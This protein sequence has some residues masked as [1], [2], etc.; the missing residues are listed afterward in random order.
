MHITPHGG[1]GEGIGTRYSGYKLIPE[2]IMVP[3]VTFER[4]ELILTG[5]LLS[6]TFTSTSSTDVCTSQLELNRLQTMVIAYAM[7]QSGLETTAIAL[8][9]ITGD[10]G[11][12]IRDWMS[13]SHIILRQ[14]E[15]RWHIEISKNGR[16]RVERRVK[17]TGLRS[18]RYH[19]RVCTHKILMQLVEH[20]GDSQCIHNNAQFTLVYPVTIGDPVFICKETGYTVR[21]I[22]GEFRALPP[23]SI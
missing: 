21:K 12:S 18:W 5:P 20:T 4:V 1:L 8:L 9:G 6:S 3:G 15:H 16:V 22:D 2:S 17:Y 14:N 10:E 7:L 23:T 19:C 11:I 13:E